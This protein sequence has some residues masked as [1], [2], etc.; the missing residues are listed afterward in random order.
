VLDIEGIRRLQLI[1]NDESYKHSHLFFETPHKGL[2][3]FH[4]TCYTH[5]LETCHV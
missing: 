5:P 4:S 3:F 2:F 1:R